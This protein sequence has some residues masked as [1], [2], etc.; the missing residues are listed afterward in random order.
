MIRSAIVLGIKKFIDWF[1]LRLWLA[2]NRW[3]ARK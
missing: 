3:E 1:S 2:R